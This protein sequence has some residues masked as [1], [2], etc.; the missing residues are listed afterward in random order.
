M[1]TKRKIG[2]YYY[3][4]AGILSKFFCFFSVVVVCRMTS[5]LSNDISS[6]ATGPVKPKCHLWHSWAGG[7]KVYVLCGNCDLNLVAMSA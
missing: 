7:L 2:N 6:E 4:T 5:I 3:V 1:E